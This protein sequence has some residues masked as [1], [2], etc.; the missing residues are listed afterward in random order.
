MPNERPPQGG[1]PR[2]LAA[3]GGRYLD[4]SPENGKEIFASTLISAG[5]ARSV[6]NLAVL[7]SVRC[8]AK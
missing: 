2:R 6:D 3:V 8:C 5:R 4:R 1:G 7:G